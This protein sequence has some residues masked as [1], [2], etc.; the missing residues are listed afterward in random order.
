MLKASVAFIRAVHSGEQRGQLPPPGKLKFFPN[1][2]FS[3]SELFLIAILVQNVNH[4]C[5]FANA[6]LHCYS[7]FELWDLSNFLPLFAAVH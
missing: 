1:I 6:S 3:F 5:D 2:V 4:D 7:A